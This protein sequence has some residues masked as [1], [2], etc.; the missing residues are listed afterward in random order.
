MLHLCL[1][2][3]AEHEGSCLTLLCACPQ[4]SIIVPPEVGYGDKGLQEI[5]PNGTFELRVEILSIA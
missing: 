1:L 2:A 3:S 4:R 5:P